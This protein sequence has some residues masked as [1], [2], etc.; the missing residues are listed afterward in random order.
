MSCPLAACL[1]FLAAASSF[2]EGMLRQTGYSQTVY[3]AT[4]RLASP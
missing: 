1:A 3:D 2:F 4:A